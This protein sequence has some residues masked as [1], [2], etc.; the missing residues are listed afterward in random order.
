MRV[1]SY[2]LALL[3]GFAL[4]GISAALGGGVAPLGKTGPA[5]GVLFFIPIVA[6][7]LPLA[8][9]AFVRGHALTGSWV[10][11]VAPVFGLLN[12]ALAV[13]AKMAPSSSLALRLSEPSMLLF[14]W[15]LLLGL[16]LGALM[17]F[18]RVP[19]HSPTR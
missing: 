4:W 2:L 11:A 1:L 6:F 9:I 14:V 7:A 10:L 15:L 17:L 5:E 16:A 19:P 18:G 8:A 3:V 12:F 13:S